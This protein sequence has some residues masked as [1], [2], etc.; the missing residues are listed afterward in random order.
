MAS[1]VKVTFGLFVIIIIIGIIIIYVLLFPFFK[2]IHLNVKY[3]LNR[4][5]GLIV[6]ACFHIVHRSV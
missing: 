1:C 5:F 3:N 2:I 6:G 4:G